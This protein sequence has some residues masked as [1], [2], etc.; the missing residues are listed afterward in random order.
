MLQ[1]LYIKLTP[2]ATR[3][4]ISLSLHGVEWS[5]DSGEIIVVGIG[6]YRNQ[7]T[8]EVKKEISRAE[9]ITGHQMFI[10]QI[11][12]LIPKD[13]EIIDDS[14][15]I[16]QSKHADEIRKNR[17]EAIVR[18]ARS[19]KRVVS[20]SSG[21]PGIYGRAG[22]IIEGAK[23]LGI[24]VRILPGVAVA[25]TA[26]AVFG[27]PLMDGFVLI[28]LCEDAVPASLIKK[29]LM[30]AASSD[31]TIVL[32]A[33]KP[34]A[35]L[36]PEFYPIDFYP[37]FQPLDK[38]ANKRLELAQET[39]MR[40]RDPQTPVGILTYDAR[41]KTEEAILTKLEKLNGEYD[42]IDFLSTV[43]IGNSATKMIDG[44]MV[45]TYWRQKWPW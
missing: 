7:I 45:N 17:T 43:I 10:E 40:F 30:C 6:C 19:G 2:T 11:K 4:G 35:L 33:P 16:K 31:M 15:L 29:R 44:R 18:A 32:Y 8:E 34:E 28:G 24:P 37:E 41:S 22:H 39:L 26:A 12:D 3:L 13:A 27:A 23:G 14:K 1:K 25:L 38:K 21:D 5:L 42:K 20:I 9:V 36:Y